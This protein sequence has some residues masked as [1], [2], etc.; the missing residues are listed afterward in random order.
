MKSLVRDLEFVSWKDELAGLEHMK[1]DEFKKA[2]KE[3]QQHFNKAYSNINSSL[4]K[5]WLFL[6]NKLP[7]DYPPYYSFRWQGHTVYVC[8]QNRYIPSVYIEI[9]DGSKLDFGGVRAFG[10]GSNLF[11]C[12][13][14]LSS[15][16]EHLTLSI[17]SPILRRLHAIPNVGESAATQGDLIFYTTTENIFW[18]NNVY[19]IDSVGKK[20]H[21]YEEDEEKYVL[22]L[23]KPK[24]QEDVFILRKSALMQDI[25]II[26]NNTV[27]WLSKGFGTKLPINKNCIAFNS[28]FMHKKTKVFYPKEHYLVDVYSRE[29]VLIFIFCKDAMQCLYMYVNSWRPII[30]LQVCELKFAEESEMIIMGFPNAPDRT[31][32]LNKFFIPI[33][34]SELKG[35]KFA[36]ESGNSP[37][38][39]FV[40]KPQGR[41]RGL[42][43][44][45]Y[46]SYGT[47]MRKHQSRLWIP[48]L[49][50]NFMIASLCVRGGNEN[51]DRWWDASRTAQ[52]RK[53]GV[54]DFVVGV[55][56]LQKYFKFDKTNTIIYGRSA[57]G[58][59]VTA[60][61]KELQ[62]SIAVVYAAKPYTDLLRT[63]TN[64]KALQAKQETD[65][66][67]L[68]ETPEQVLDFISL[69][70]ISPYENVNFPL[71]PKTPAVLLTAG[72]N[73][74][75]VPA[76]MPIR[77]AKRLQ[78][79][80]W[81]NAFCRVEVGEGH[82][83]NLGNESG[84][85]FDG[86]FCESILDT[87]DEAGQFE[88]ST[89]IE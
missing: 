49:K 18:F 48:W 32:N 27:R 76:F 75:E 33:V 30:N 57:G 9:M 55:H 16:K 72:T 11:W 70:Q 23:I 29:H 54:R 21:I 89:D 43:V 69:S 65:E 66:F 15:G 2:L 63:T 85:A 40:V 88:H 50:R 42:V 38:P 39:W 52:R 78:T 68:V 17:Y 80:G 20:H 7:L 34:M 82:F 60:A 46:G 22:K 45:G 71:K 86:A 56:Y 25:G 61:L 59:L 62:D 13:Q 26:E 12:I 51:G 47:A 4:K 67:G 53:Y 5:Q 41:P 79:Y 58:F 64:T 44:C 74:S 19:S 84:E 6:F 36:L 28:F 37:I 87:I 8:Q 31:I 35:P 14:D 10:I 81:E 77:Y 1:T 83:T 73:D 3:Q 24:G